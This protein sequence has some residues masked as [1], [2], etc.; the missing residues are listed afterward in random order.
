MNTTAIAHLPKLIPNLRTLQLSIE[1]WKEK[2]AE[3]GSLK[4]RAWRDY[5]NAIDMQ[6]PRELISDLLGNAMLF[7]DICRDAW[8]EWEAV[9][10]QLLD[11]LN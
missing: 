4:E 1:F 10:K 6:L 8:E 5:D 7:D 9:K 11:Y 2:Y 3:A